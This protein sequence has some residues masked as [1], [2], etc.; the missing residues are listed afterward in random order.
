MRRLIILCALFVLSA[1]E[2]RQTVTISVASSLQDVMQ[3]LA[4]DYEKQY[5]ETILINSGGSD[6]LLSQIEAGFDVDLFVPADDEMIRD[7]ENSQRVLAHDSLATTTLALVTSHD[8]FHHFEQLQDEFSILLASSSVPIGAY[9]LEVLAHYDESHPG[10]SERVLTHV[11]SYEQNVRHVLL[12]IGLKEADVGFV[13]RTDLHIPTTYPLTEINIP[14][15][16]PI[17]QYEV[18]L[19]TDKGISFYEFL[20]TS[21]AKEVL[22][23]YGYE[24]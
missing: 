17:V 9:S 1:C 19:L 2:S 16:S 21:Q 4:T 11:V 7:L 23:A 13:Y 5:H 15:A 14:V 24:N 18:A 22:Q 8:E 12:K 10:F 20:Q 3:T 6:T